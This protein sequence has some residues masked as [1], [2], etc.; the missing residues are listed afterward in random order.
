MWDGM[1]LVAKE[2]PLVNSR[3][4]ILMLSENTG[5]HEEIGEAALTVNPFDVQEQAD[6]IHFALTA[7]PAERARRMQNLK[8][9]ITARS[10]GDWIDDQLVDVDA[11]RGGARAGTV[12]G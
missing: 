2:G 4:G 10:P 1:N 5:A 6:A 3:D 8:N 11:K 7:S 9:V 12:P